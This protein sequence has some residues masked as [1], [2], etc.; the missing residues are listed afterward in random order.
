[1]FYCCE[2]RQRPYQYSYLI[3]F[4]LFLMEMSMPMCTFFFHT[5]SK[6]I[7]FCIE[8]RNVYT[9]KELTV[10]VNCFHL[11]YLI[12]FVPCWR[13]DQKV[14]ICYFPW[15]SLAL[16]AWILIARFYDFKINKKQANKLRT[17]T[18][19]SIQN[20]RY[21][22]TQNKNEAEEEKTQSKLIEPI[23]LIFCM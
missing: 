1:M 2:F 10:T 14:I 16:T 11:F 21:K 18:S 5:L 23:P 20:E 3:S 17:T 8:A 15:F 7:P 13:P 6:R 4:A 22:Y 12:H 19:Y 9:E